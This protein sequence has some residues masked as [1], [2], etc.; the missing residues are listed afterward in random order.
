MWIATNQEQGCDGA[1]ESQ[2]GTCERYATK[3][4]DEREIDGVPHER[5]FA[6]RERFRKIDSGEAS[7]LR[8]ERLPERRGDIDVFQ[9][10]SKR[11]IE[12]RKDGDAQD[13]NRE[14]TGGSRDGVV[15]SGSHSGPV[16]RDG[17][18]DGGRQRR[19]AHG[20]AEPENDDGGKE[21][22]PI[23]AANSGQREE[24]KAG[25]RNSRADDQRNA[26]AILL[27]ERTRP[28][29]EQEHDEDEGQQGRAGRGG[30]VTLHLDQIEGQEKQRPAQRGVEE[31]SQQVRAGEIARAK[32]RER[33]HGI[34]AARFENEKEREENNGADEGRAN[35][36]MREPARRRFDQTINER[37]Q[38]ESGEDR[39]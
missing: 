28:A 8:V 3:T 6:R 35:S 1:A 26:R 31:K 14:Q 29:R 38:A 30:T 20:H 9:A 37:T 16:A 10:P 18:H 32:K 24:S 7:A 21:C 33:Q 2:R 4:I 36:R 27:H 19:D 17:I 12:N 5:T 39:A 34:F 13:G 25:S 11:P 23:G 22:G 15:H